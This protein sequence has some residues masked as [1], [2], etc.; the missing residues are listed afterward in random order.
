[1]A[2]RSSDNLANRTFYIKYSI[3]LKERRYENPS[4]TVVMKATFVYKD[5]GPTKS[6]TEYFKEVN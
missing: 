5:G 6:I 3:H 2:V 1:M 4:T